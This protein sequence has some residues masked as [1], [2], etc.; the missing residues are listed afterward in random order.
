MA[1]AAF[2][3]LGK[4]KERTGQMYSS[5]RELSRNSTLFRTIVPYYY[6]VTLNCYIA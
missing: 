2:N 6:Q 5:V 3:E 1:K 4:G